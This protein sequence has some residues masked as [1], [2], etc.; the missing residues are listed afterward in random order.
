MKENLSWRELR[1]AVVAISHDTGNA[2]EYISVWEAGK[3]MSSIY[4]CKQETARKEIRRAI[5][6]GG[7]RYNAKWK[8]KEQE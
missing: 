6:S 7:I 8:Y 5:H 4:G 1:K 2:H 3:E